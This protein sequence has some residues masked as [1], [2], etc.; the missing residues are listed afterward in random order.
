[1]TTPTR[2][3]GITAGALAAAR[4]DPRDY[5]AVAAAAALLGGPGGGGAVTDA[6]LPVSRAIEFMFLYLTSSTAPNGQ[7]IIPHL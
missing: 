5:H 1:M 2:L 6:E 3:P 4:R 7:P